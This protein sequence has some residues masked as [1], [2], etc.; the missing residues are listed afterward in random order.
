METVGGEAPP[1]RDA[2]PRPSGRADVRREERWTVAGLVAL[3]AVI[4]AVAL[5]FGGPA[6]YLDTL[7]PGAG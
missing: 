6:T 5:L 3:A 4:Y 1:D 2:A 7:G